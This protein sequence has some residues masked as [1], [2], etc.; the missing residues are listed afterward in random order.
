[1]NSSNDHNDDIAVA[2]YYLAEARGFN[3]DS[4]LDD[5][6]AAE[7]SLRSQDTTLDN[8]AS[9]VPKQCCPG[10][11]FPS[12]VNSSAMQAWTDAVAFLA[13]RVA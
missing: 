4:Q 11:D 2:A 6:L 1:M 9:D 7:R 8:V 3:G 13:K 12:Q 10:Q 5:W